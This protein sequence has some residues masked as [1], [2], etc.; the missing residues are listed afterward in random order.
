MSTAADAPS[1]LARLWHVGA[2]GVVAVALVGYAT[3]TRN[4]PTA[5]RVA[6]DDAAREADKMPSYAEIGEERRGPNAELYTTAFPLLESGK[7]GAFEPVVQSAEEHQAVVTARAA[8]RAYD[9]APPTVPHDVV[10]KGFPDCLSCH[11]RGAKVAGKRAPRMSHARY[12]NCTQCHVPSRAPAPLPPADP[13]VENAFVGAPSPGAGVRAWPGAPPTIPHSTLMRSECAS[14]H[15]T[16]GLNGIRSTHPYRESCT[17]C[18]V[19]RA[20]LDQRAPA[21][22]ER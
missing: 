12:D 4:P 10:Q 5:S 11:E 22:A 19:S 3:A 6:P 21:E 13:P 8:R 16:G 1:P 2:A 15:G 17:Q 14:C 18:H 7:P 9:G 20:E